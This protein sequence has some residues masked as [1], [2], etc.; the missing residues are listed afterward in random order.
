MDEAWNSSSWIRISRPRINS[1]HTGS[2]TSMSFSD[3][4]LENRHTKLNSKTNS[5]RLALQIYLL[6]SKKKLLRR[7][8]F[9]WTQSIS[10]IGRSQ[11]SFT[12]VL[13]RLLWAKRCYRHPRVFISQG[14]LV[15]GMSNRILSQCLRASRQGNWSFMMALSWLEIQYWMSS[16]SRNWIRYSHSQ[17][18][19]VRTIYKSVTCI[20]A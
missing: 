17:V 1:L 6:T 18:F 20:S 11:I 14:K 13:W 10:L 5:P 12:A 16:N 2:L 19:W 15:C 4:R 3:L 9:E 7:Y 8:L